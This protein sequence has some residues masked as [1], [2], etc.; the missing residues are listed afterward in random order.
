MTC[1]KRK[2]EQDGVPP[3]FFGDYKLP[4]TE[5]NTKVDGGFL[6]PFLRRLD[7]CAHACVRPMHPHGSRASVAHPCVIL[8]C[9]G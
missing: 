2:E 4:S 1:R 8:A 6:Q 5:C 3:S 9:A 7:R